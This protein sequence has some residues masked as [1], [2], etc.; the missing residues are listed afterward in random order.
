M[1]LKLA[2]IGFSLIC[3]S[4]AAF[5]QKT[6][7]A[8]VISGKDAP[9]TLKLKDLTG[10]WRR[11][12]FIGTTMTG[13]GME[14]LMGLM[15]NLGP[16]MQ[17]GMMSEMGKGA[18]KNAGGGAGMDAM[19]PAMASMFGGMFGS[20]DP[21]YYTKGQTVELGSET[22]LITYRHK[23]PK[24]DFMQMMMGVDKPGAGGKAA[25]AKANDPAKMMEAGKL[26]PD[27][28]LAI[29]LINTKAIG[30]IN[31]L[32]PFD[33]Q[34]EIEEAKA[35][36]GLADL[37]AAGMKENE[38]AKVN[39]AGKEIEASPASASESVESEIDLTLKTDATLGKASNGIKV[40]VV[41]NV[42][43]LTGSVKTAQLQQR[44]VNLSNRKIKEMGGGYTVRNEIKVK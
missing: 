14:G 20:G 17:A 8:S 9:A 16:L 37:M 11:M 10:D 13:S 34:K 21:V 23:A 6:D 27:S 28:D 7:I 5:A 40:K 1:K 12:K 35:A 18:A 42:V 30:M 24:M 43:I 29:N 41:D 36:N 15:S 44:A 31:D 38:G 19:M 33:M 22:F 2:V 26:N 39:E 3:C 4:G 32:R 25:D